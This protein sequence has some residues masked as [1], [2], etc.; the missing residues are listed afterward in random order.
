MKNLFKEN[1]IEMIQIILFAIL[2]VYAAVDWIDGSLLI[3]LLSSTGI[4][5]VTNVIMLKRQRNK[6]LKRGE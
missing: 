5:L 1:C 3:I 2:I 6:L 4:M